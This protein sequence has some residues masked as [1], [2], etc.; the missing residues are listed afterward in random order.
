MIILTAVFIHSLSISFVSC[1]IVH[2]CLVCIIF[3]CI[4]ALCSFMFE[5]CFHLLSHLPFLFDLHSIIKAKFCSRFD[6][7]FLAKHKLK[8][9]CCGK[10][11]TYIILMVI[12]TIIIF[13]ATNI[14]H[15]ISKHQL[16][17]NMIELF[18]VG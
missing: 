9:I 18:M 4:F 11:C 16:L 3:K 7:F 5:F 15:I 6:F 13:N 14:G 1:I 10:I 8:C 2:P 17:K 12:I